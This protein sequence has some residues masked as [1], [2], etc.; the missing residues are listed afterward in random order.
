MPVGKTSVT[1][2]EGSRTLLLEKSKTESGFKKF[3]KKIICC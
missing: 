2:G 3:L 1:I